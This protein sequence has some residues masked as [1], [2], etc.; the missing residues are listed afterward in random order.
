VPGVP[1]VFLDQVA[2]EPAQAGPATVR[3]R[4]ADR[5]VQ[6]ASSQRAIGGSH[7]A[8]V[9]DAIY[10]RTWGIAA[11]AAGR[12]DRGKLLRVTALPVFD[13]AAF[14]AA[15]DAERRDRGLGWYEFADELWQQ[16]SQ[17][18]AQLM[19]HPLCGGAVSR[20]GARGATSCQYA[21][22]MLRWLGRAP[23]E[24]L[25]GPVVDVGD[26]R[27]PRPGPGS[28]L[29]W[30]LDQL[31]T[32]LNE[33]RTERGL[34]WSQLAQELG[35]TPGRLTNLRTARLADMGLVM[36]ITQWLGKPAAEFVHAAD[37]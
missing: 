11:R 29:R 4:Q 14:F 30:D 13:F 20:L 12:G 7:G 33:R 37:W 15:F 31:H 24:F 19:D 23:E 25:T 2:Q 17:L 1:T 16:S 5:L 21:L 34:T 18:N 35:C 8:A 32:T 22:F 3:P 36:R 6:P 27:L 9:M 28:R 26:N 10:L